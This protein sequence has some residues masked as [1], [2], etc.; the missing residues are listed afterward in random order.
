MKNWMPP[1]W[2][3]VNSCWQQL[4]T[5]FKV[6]GAPRLALQPSRSIRAQAMSN[7]RWRKQGI[8]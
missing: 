8:R 1:D 5:L 7:A 3:N 2:L 4:E 6:N